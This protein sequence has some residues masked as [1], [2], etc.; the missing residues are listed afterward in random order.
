MP[1]E[2]NEDRYLEARAESNAVEHGEEDG[3]IFKEITDLLNRD[4]MRA[5]RKEQSNLIR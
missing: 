1:D 5:I 4:K 2:E 3:A